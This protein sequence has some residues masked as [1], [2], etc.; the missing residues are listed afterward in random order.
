[1]ISKQDIKIIYGEWYGYEKDTLMKVR[2]DFTI[3]TN[4]G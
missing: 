4:K 2:L 1:M 3:Y